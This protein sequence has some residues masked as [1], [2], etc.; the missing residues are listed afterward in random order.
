MFWVKVS[1]VVPAEH[2]LQ[3]DQIEN[4]SGCTA[5]HK[6]Q[7]NDEQNPEKN[8]FLSDMRQSLSLTTSPM[9][10][11]PKMHLQRLKDASYDLCYSPMTYYLQMMDKL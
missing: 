10:L 8:N 4:G 6:N 7:H 5:D 3:F 9:S 2:V 11:I 1:E